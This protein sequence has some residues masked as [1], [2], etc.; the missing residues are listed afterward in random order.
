MKKFLPLILF[1]MF[2][3]EAQGAPRYRYSAVEAQALLEQLATHVMIINSDMTLSR[4]APANTFDLLTYYPLPKD[5]VKAYE[6][7]GHITEKDDD[8]A[9][10]VTYKIK[11]YALSNEKSEALRL[12]ESGGDASLQDFALWT[13]DKVL[14][15][16]LGLA[17]KLDKRFERVKGHMTIVFE[18][19]GKLTRE[20]RVPVNLSVTD[21]DPRPGT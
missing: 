20:V 11:D 5:Q 17:V 21:K 19:P 14:S 18:M 13:Y 10:F 6:R 4:K 1:V 12:Q 8:I 2:A 7:N 9:D 3:C 16:Q 15:G